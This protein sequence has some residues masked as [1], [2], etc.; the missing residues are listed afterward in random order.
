MVNKIK[1]ID[2]AISM[3]LLQ[4]YLPENVRR[5]LDTMSNGAVAVD[6]QGRIIWCNNAAEEITGYKSQEMFGKAYTDY[7]GKD[8]RKERSLLSTLGTKAAIRNRQKKIV[9]AKGTKVPVR[10]STSILTDEHDKIIGAIEIFED[11]SPIKK[12]KNEIRNIRSLALLG[13]MTTTVAHTIKNPLG[14]IAGYATLLERDLQADDPRRRLVRKIVDG[15]GGMDRVLKTLDIFRDP[16]TPRLQKL[17]LTKVIDDILAHVQ[18]T[19]QQ[20]SRALRIV[21]SFTKEE[22][23]TELDPELFRESVFNL[24]QNVIQVAPE[25]GQLAVEIDKITNSRVQIKI[26]YL[27][28]APK[29]EEELPYSFAAAK[30]KIKTLSFAVAHKVVTLHQGS[31]KLESQANGGITIRIT[32]PVS[33][34]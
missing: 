12:L 27:G 31:I 14:A 24:V 4:G 2:Q 26:S 25:G 18:H 15:V 3:N 34:K 11:L 6:A 29:P 33:S 9:T 10:F 30:T 1:D 28:F 13:E 21:K 23:E 16:F 5:V 22:I 19:M 7:L 20:E 17:E 32:L 8:V